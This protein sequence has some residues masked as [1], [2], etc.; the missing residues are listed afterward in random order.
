MLLEFESQPNM[1]NEPTAKMQLFLHSLMLLCCFFRF[2]WN[3][4]ENWYRKRDEKQGAQK[5]TTTRTTACNRRFWKDERSKKRKTRARIWM[6][7]QFYMICNKSATTTTDTYVNDVITIPKV[8]ACIHTPA[9]LA[10][11]HVHQHV[12]WI[13]DLIQTQSF[14][15]FY[16]SSVSSDFTQSK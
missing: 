13:V 16:R 9:H 7:V 10:N 11:A 15:S 3:Y 5:T 1:M 14:Q 4:T 2:I 12:H 6:L 8:H